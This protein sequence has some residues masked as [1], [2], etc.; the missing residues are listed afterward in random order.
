MPSDD[1]NRVNFAHFWITDSLP[2][3]VDIAKHKPF[4]LL[5]LSDIIADMLLAYDLKQ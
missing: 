1:S 5:S 2:L 4:E 3:A